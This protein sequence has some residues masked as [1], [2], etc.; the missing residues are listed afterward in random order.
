MATLADEA[1]AYEPQLTK[2]IADLDI[3]ET[4]LQV[5]DRE[6]LDNEGKPF[7]YKVIIVAGTEYRVPGS[8]LSSLKE[9]MVKK[10]DLKKFSVS[11]TGQ[12]FNTKY[13]VIPQI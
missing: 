10:P 9:I 7:K 5:L 13:T 3:V 2:N 1:K 6:G 12:G 8:V 11:K 4:N